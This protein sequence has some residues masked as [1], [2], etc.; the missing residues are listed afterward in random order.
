MILYS[1]E[2][3]PYM[4]LY[5][6]EDDP[7]LIFYSPEGVPCMIFSAMKAQAQIL[8]LKFMLFLVATSKSLYC[9]YCMAGVHFLASKKKGQS[10]PTFQKVLLITIKTD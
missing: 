6:T 3:V 2:G 5:S 4:I 7:C 10:F 8:C 9:F 1:P